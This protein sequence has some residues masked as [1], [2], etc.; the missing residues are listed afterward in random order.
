MKLYDPATFRYG[1][2]GQELPVRVDEMGTPYLKAALTIGEGE[3]IEGEFKIDSAAGATLMF[4]SPFAAHHQL[5]AAI[6]A[7]GGKTVADSLA[8]V[9]GTSQTWYARLAQ[10]RVGATVF[11]KPVVT[12][13]EAKGG[14]LARTDIAGAIGAG[15]MHRFKVTYDCPHN[16]I[17]LEPTERIGLPFE[18]DM[19]GVSWS[20]A[21]GEYRVRAVAP[22]SA[23]A[24]AGMEP[25]DVLVSMD[26]RTAAEF[27]PA[28]LGKRL[29]TPGKV[30]LVVRRGQHEVNV[31]LTLARLV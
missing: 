1:G 24:H 12:I 14:T 15:L 5:L 2:P 10:L 28:T 9:G 4:A 11:D 30:R 26:G 7:A 31:E 27:T 29:M 23:A 20:N 18:R 8:G 13:T 22:D 25:G 19:S 16:R 6:R 3:P 17:Y 21:G